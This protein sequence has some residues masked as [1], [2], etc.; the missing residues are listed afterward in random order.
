MGHHQLQQQYL[1]QQETEET[2]FKRY[3][4]NR[5]QAQAE[6]AEEFLAELERLARGAKLDHE[7]PHSSLDALI[8]ER[9]VLGLKDSHAQVEPSVY[10]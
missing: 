2:R 10:N 7:M 3:F 8:R 5:T 4:Y 6:K 9:F 1:H